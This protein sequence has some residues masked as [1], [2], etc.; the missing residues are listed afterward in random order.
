MPLSWPARE[1]HAWTAG[2]VSW[3]SLCRGRAA[4]LQ[5]LWTNNEVIYPS[6][7][8]VFI[9]NFVSNIWLILSRQCNEY[10]KVIIFTL[11]TNVII[12]IDLRKHREIVIPWPCWPGAIKDENGY[13][14]NITVFM[15]ISFAW[16]YSYFW[17]VPSKACIFHPRRTCRNLIKYGHH[18]IWKW[19]RFLVKRRHDNTLR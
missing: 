5:V 15:N 9:P 18:V 7:L 1:R 11:F 6:H 8:A 16:V 19:L 17:W 14:E 12:L 10:S 2:L 4:E 13:R 3:R